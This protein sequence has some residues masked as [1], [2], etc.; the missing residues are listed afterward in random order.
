LKQKARD[1]MDKQE[2]LTVRLK[3]AAGSGDLSELERALADGADARKEDSWALSVAAGGGHG[4]CVSRLIAVSDAKAQESYA[5]RWAAAAGHLDCVRLL[6]P[7]SDP[8]AGESRA[9]RWAA[10][11]GH[12]EMV[13]LLLP[14]SDPLAVGDEGL[15]AAAW[16]RKERHMEV[17]GMIEAFIEAGALASGLEDAG[18][19]SKA[20][21]SL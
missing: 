18:P 11:N 14:V 10:G 20:K 17:A 4:A 7:A 9:L 2:D 5:L 19:R 15:D 3:E 8:L 13:R 1:A 16:A 6:I 21:K 12:V